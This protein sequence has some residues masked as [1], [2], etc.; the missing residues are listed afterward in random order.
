MECEL[1]CCIVPREVN[2][3][4]QL[5]VFARRLEREKKSRRR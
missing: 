4:E 5:M 2:F 3:E 1:V